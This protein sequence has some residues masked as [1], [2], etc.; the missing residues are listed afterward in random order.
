MKKEELGNCGKNEGKGWEREDGDG[1]DGDNDVGR[2][3]G[4][5]L[6]KMWNY[7]HGVGV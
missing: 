1:I 5:A 7:H 4:V 3:V 2:S 6:R